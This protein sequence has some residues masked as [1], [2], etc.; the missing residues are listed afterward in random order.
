[1]GSARIRR[2]PS[3]SAG[4][5]WTPG[6]GPAGCRWLRR[7]DAVAEV[8][9]QVGRG[10]DFIT[11]SP[12]VPAEWLVGMIRAARRRTCPCGRAPREGWLLALR[13]G[14]AVA[15]PLISGDPELLPQA[16]R[17]AFE[18]RTTGGGS[19]VLAAWL[20]RLES[21][22]PDVERAVTAVLANDATLA[23]LLASAAGRV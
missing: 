18:T 16:E 8:E 9:R 13:A 11:I 20:E 23:P 12:G 5:C 3:T 7:R 4:P 21:D 2:R 10:A 19:G 6:A 1:M 22:G 14:A 17:N 15:S